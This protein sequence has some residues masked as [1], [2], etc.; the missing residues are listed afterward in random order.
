MTTNFRVGKGIGIAYDSTLALFEPLN[1]A[2]AESLWAL[3][4]DG[5]GIDE[6]LEELSTTGLRSLGSFAMAQFEDSQIR[7]VVRGTARARVSGA[8]GPREIGAAGVRTWVE[9]VVDGVD[10]VELALDELDGSV[11][12]FRV[13]R[14]LLPADVLQQANSQVVAAPA[15]QLDGMALDWADDFHA[16]EVFVVPSLETEAAAAV[17]EVEASVASVA[18]VPQPEPAPAV[19]TV[20]PEAEPEPTPESEPDPTP[21]SYTHLTLPTNREV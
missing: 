7:I 17:D 6:L 14:G 1:G 9:E 13:E 11:L 20:A 12:P 18:A 19:V 2:L 8:G 4:A 15:P 16:S 21:V 3:V 10:A 5:A